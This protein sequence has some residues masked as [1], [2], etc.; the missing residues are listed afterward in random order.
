M[1]EASQHVSLLHFFLALVR[2]PP[3]KR[4]DGAARLF[5]QTGEG[6]DRG[7]IGA[8]I[9]LLW[10]SIFDILNVFCSFSK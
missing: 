5:P 1:D 6:L 9:A 8:V 3:C 2:A 4:Q 7:V 10:V